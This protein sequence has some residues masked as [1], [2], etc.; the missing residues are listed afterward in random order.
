M[1]TNDSSAKKFGYSFEQL[2]D[3]LKNIDVA[4]GANEETA[5]E[6]REAVLR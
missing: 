1:F 4:L 5:Y 2:K 3:P 6:S